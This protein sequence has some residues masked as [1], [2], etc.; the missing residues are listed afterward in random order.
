MRVINLA[1]GSKGNSTLVEHSE[2]KILVDVGISIRELETRLMRAG[3]RLEEISAIIV[4]HDHVDHIKSVAKLSNK[5]NIPVYASSE[6]FYNSNLSQVEDKNKRYVG[7]E[8][9]SVGDIEIEVVDLSHDASRTLGFIFYCD[10]NKVGLVTDLGYIDELILSK[11]KG[12]NLVMIE[13]N[14]DHEMLMSGPYPL[15]LKRRISSRMGHLSNFDCARAILELSKRGTEYFMLMHLSETN[16]SPEIAY[17]T[18]MKCLFDEY[19]ENSKVRV[20]IAEQC[21]ISPNFV[22]KHRKE[23]DA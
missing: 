16:N 14:Y 19:G 12:S 6:C 18:T 4:S 15:V 10:G 20:M 11:L 1:S 8:N 3:G 23:G 7:I 9:F 13:S 5:Y 21:D 17:N 22:F 2:Y